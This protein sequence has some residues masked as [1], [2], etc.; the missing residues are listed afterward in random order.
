MARQAHSL[1]PEQSL[2]RKRKVVE[3][4]DKH[5]VSFADIATRLGFAAGAQ[6]SAAYREMK[7]E[8]KE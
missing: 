8:K 6:A 4:K 2:A 1:T 3:L 7:K 5:G